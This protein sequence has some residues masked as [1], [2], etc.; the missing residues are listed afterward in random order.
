MHLTP[1]GRAYKGELEEFVTGTPLPL[2]DIV[3][4]PKDGAMYF[5]IGGR[6]TQSGL[7]RVTYVG[8]ESTAPSKTDQRPVR[9]TRLRQQARGLPRQAG[10][11][12]RRDGLALPGPRGSLH[13]LRRPRRHRASG[14]QGPGRSA[15]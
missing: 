1:D 7:Y 14:S 10:P 2:T 4:N 6:K 12:G 3:V 15:P 13:P 5:T 11:E 8:T 9:C